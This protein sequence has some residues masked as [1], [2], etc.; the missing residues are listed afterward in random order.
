MVLKL[1][2]SKGLSKAKLKRLCFPCYATTC[3]RS[4]NW[5]RMLS[6]MLSI[7]VRKFLGISLRVAVFIYI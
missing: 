4:S 7:R 5:E 1:S 6:H 2:Q 3:V